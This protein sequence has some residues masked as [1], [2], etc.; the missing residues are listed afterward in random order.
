M[1]ISSKG[2]FTRVF[3]SDIRQSLG[4]LRLYA[5]PNGLGHPRLGMSLSRKFGIAV[6]R[7]RLKRLL[8]EAFRLSQGLFPAGYDV[9]IVPKPHELLEMETYRKR[10]AQ[11]I[12]TL[13]S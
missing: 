3:H 10:L 7:N 12:G 6:K 5:L 1:R 2:D 4:P 8:R 11:F 9:L 13:P